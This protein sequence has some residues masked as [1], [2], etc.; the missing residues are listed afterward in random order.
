MRVIRNRYLSLAFVAL[1]AAFLIVSCGGRG[2]STNYGT[3]PPPPSP[4]PP[5]GSLHMHAVSIQNFA[6]TPASLAVA[7]GDTVRWTNNDGTT[8]TVTSDTGSE[9][10]GQ[11]SS[12]QSYLHVFSAAGN[13]TYHCSIHTYM[14]GSVTSQ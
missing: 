14:M 1:S 6:F 3:N 2:N 4:P 11:L 9:L 7:A 13:F 12:G 5:G 10:S 8:H